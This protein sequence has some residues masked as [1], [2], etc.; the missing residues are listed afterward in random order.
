LESDALLR[1]SSPGQDADRFL[2]PWNKFYELRDGDQALLQGDEPDD[3]AGQDDA[4][5]VREDLA[6]LG[7]AV[8][9]N[10]LVEVRSRGI[11]GRT[12]FGVDVTVRDPR[13][14]VLTRWGER[15]GGAFV[16]SDG[17]GVIVHKE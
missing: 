5:A 4:V 9:E 8:Q 1:Q 2:L 13:G 7:L 6:L 15:R 14:R 3:E 11:L 12:G 10:L 16:M 17:T